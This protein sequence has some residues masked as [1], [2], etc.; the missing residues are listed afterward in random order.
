M[1]RSMSAFAVV[2]G[3]KADV[4]CCTAYVRFWPLAD[5]ASCAAH[6]CFQGQSRHDLLRESAFAV[7]IG[8]KADIAFAAQMSAYDPKRTLRQA[9]NELYLDRYNAWVAH[10]LREKKKKRAWR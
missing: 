8:V 9:L 1:N 7:A 10:P 5:I 4:G 6:V 3:G 2:V